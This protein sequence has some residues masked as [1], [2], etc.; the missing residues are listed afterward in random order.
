MF[1]SVKCPGEHVGVVENGD[2]KKPG[3]TGTGK[4]GQFQPKVIHEVICCDVY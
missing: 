3:S 2:A 4:H 1:E